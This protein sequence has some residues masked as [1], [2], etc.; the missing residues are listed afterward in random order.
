MPRVHYVKKARKDNSAVKAGEP[1]FWWKFRHGG[2]HCSK[3]QPRP[4]QLTQSDKLSRAYA[5]SERLD[6]LCEDAINMDKDSI[7]NDINEVAEEVRTISDEYN[8]SADNMECVFTG[9]NPTI[10]ECRE[11][12]DGL[13]GWADEIEQAASE[14]ESLEDDEDDFADQVVNVIEG[15]S[16]GCPI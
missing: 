9:G 15:V 6:D 2:K 10:D 8:E 11:K 4:S 16:G 1:Y 14:V 12:A 5:A 7:V 13:E 3:T